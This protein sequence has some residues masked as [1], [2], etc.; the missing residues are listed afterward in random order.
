MTG[1]M[2]LLSFTGKPSEKRRKAWFMKRCHSDRLL[3]RP[4]EPR[5]R[6]EIVSMYEAGREIEGWSPSLE[7]GTTFDRM[8]EEW[9]DA[10]PTRYI[11]LVA[12]R[13]DG[14]APP[15]LSNVVAY[16]EIIRGVFQNAF[17]GWRTHPVLVGRGYCTEAVRLAIRYAFDDGGLQ[18]HRIQAS[19]DPEKL[20]SVRIA[21]KCGFRLEGVAQRYLFIDRKWRD[22]LIF[23]VTNEDVGYHPSPSGIS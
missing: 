14:S 6:D 7:P 4:V 9:L 18:L 5:D 11:R 1:L 23:A 15:R 21:E 13:L 22:F 2:T 12:E 19:I 17:I 10:D 20:A 16:T 8:F 3:L